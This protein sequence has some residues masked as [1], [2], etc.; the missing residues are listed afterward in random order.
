MAVLVIDDDPTMR[1]IIRLH[2]EDT[3]RTIIEAA[4]GAAGLDALRNAPEAV[5]AVFVDLNMPVM[6]GY[7]FIP[8]A[9]ALRPELPL[10]VL[11]GTG[12]V[13]DAVKAMRL[14]AWDYI[15]K[16]ILDLSILDIMLGKVFDRARLLTENRRYKQRLEELVQKRTEELEETRRQI[17][18]RLARAA[19][20]KDNRRP[21]HA[22]RVAAISRLLGRAMGLD[23]KACDL[24]WECA[25]LHDLGKIGI[26]DEILFKSGSL[27]AAER[28]ILVRHC[29]FGCEILGP[30]SSRREAAKTCSDPALILENEDNELLRL[31]RI[32]ALCHHEHWDGTGY[33]LGLE[34]DEIPLEARIVGLVD[35]FDAL[36]D[37]RPGKPTRPLDACLDII[38]AGSG[39]QFDPDVVAAFFDNLEEIIRIMQTNGD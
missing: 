27:D 30:L 14:G 21:G 3:K 34:G 8:E 15:S 1:R 13:G 36:S 12:I 10:I 38:R 6:D 18:H 5:E 23:G 2:L 16:P 7:A 39:A 22:G 35:V 20:V 28:D 32:L 29:I 11:S 9:V 4:N 26:P 37:D 24:L 25:P 17:M 33:P 31:G 19:A